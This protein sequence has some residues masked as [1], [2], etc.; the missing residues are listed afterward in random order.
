MTYNKK[1][2]FWK[3]IYHIIVQESLQIILKNS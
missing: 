2:I 1:I 3:I